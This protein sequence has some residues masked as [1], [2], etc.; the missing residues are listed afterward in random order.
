MPCLFFWL[1]IIGIIT[2]AH[3]TMLP[4]FASA[5][6]PTIAPRRSEPDIP[7]PPLNSQLWWWAN[8]GPNHDV[9]GGF[10]NQ[11]KLY[12]DGLDMGDLKADSTGFES[13]CHEHR[14]WCV[15]H[16]NPDKEELVLYFWY[17]GNNYDDVLR[18]QR[19]DSQGWAWCSLYLNFTKPF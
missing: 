1:S 15:T 5:K 18:S 7:S 16:G 10:T 4:E 6:P 9:D 13:T 17:K 3:I 2:I 12:V 19:C 11:F 8:K 14:E